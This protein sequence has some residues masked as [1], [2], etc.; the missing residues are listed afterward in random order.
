MPTTGRHDHRDPKACD[1]GGFSVLFFLKASCWCLK[2]CITTA[3]AWLGEVL[4]RRDP[5]LRSP[6]PASGGWILPGLRPLGLT[7]ATLN[8]RRLHFYFKR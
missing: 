6:T 3:F 4:G 8:S 5:G 7:A 2:N 1:A